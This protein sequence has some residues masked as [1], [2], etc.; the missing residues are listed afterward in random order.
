[1][2]EIPDTFPNIRWQCP[3]GH[4]VAGD[5]IHSEDVRDDST[6]SGVS[7]ITE[8]TC[9]GCSRPE[10]P[11]MYLGMPRIVVVGQSRMEAA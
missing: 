1:M 2:S 6:Y 9:K 5:D 10:D 7:A 11:Y 4:F 8:Y 3:R